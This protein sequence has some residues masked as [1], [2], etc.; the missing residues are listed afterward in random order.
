[1]ENYRGNLEIAKETIKFI[2]S[3]T[4]QTISNVLSTAFIFIV[5][6]VLYMAQICSVNN[7]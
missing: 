6:S 3:G 1:M 2:V 4:G 7:L 5:W